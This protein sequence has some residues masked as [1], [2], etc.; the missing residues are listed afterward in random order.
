MLISRSWIRISEG[1]PYFFMLTV[2]QAKLK[3]G[4]I[5]LHFNPTELTQHFG[6]TESRDIVASLHASP[7][8]RN[9]ITRLQVIFDP[10]KVEPCT[11]LLTCWQIL[12]VDSNST[13]IKSLDNEPVSIMT[14]KVESWQIELVR[15]SNDWTLTAENL[16]ALL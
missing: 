9:S 15:S 12:G 5:G 16:R 7:I 1:P 13:V 6:E 11:V 10:N 2:P 3:F 14:V 4:Y 8:D